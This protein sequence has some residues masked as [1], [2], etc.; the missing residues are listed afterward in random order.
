MPRSTEQPIVIA[1]GSPHG[2]DQ[3]AWDAVKLL[4]ADHSFRGTCAHAATPWDV[5]PH[6]QSGGPV[7]IIDACRSGAPAGTIHRLTAQELPTQQGMSASTHGSTL[8]D[9]LR[10]AESLGYEVSQ[11]VIY[12]IEMEA[13]QPGAPLSEVARRAA[14]ELAVQIRDELANEGKSR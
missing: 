10:F 1:L 3:A 11:V 4:S 9:A 8:E 12:A 13:C 14:E 7:F 2:D 6:L 5:V